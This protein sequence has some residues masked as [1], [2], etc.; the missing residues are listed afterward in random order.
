MPF[1]V[2]KAVS[3]TG[4]RGWHQAPIDE[5]CEM[6]ERTKGQ[7]RSVHDLVVSPIKCGIDPAFAAKKNKLQTQ[8]NYIPYSRR[9][10]TV[11]MLMI[12]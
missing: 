7:L 8:F 10:T 3:H 6:K 4:H 11:L 12:W 1:Q 2:D 5:G 9:F